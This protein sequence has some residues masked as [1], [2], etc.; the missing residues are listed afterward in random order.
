MGQEISWKI[1]VTKVNSDQCL[2]DFGL[3][4]NM[5]YINSKKYMYD[6]I[7]DDFFYDIVSRKPE[8]NDVIKMNFN[9]PK[10]QLEYHLNDNLVKFQPISEIFNVERL[11]SYSFFILIGKGDEVE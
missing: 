8:V 3:A 4:I 2:S 5:K 1:K 11:K 6:Y 9:Q 10:Q 7:H